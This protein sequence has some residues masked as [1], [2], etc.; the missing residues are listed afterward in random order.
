MIDPR[1][2]RS[3]LPEIGEFGGN[4]AEAAWN[5]NRGSVTTFISFSLCPERIQC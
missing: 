2:K 1:M 4:V 5:D 3:S